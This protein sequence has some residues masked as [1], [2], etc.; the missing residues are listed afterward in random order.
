MDEE[1]YSALTEIDMMDFGSVENHKEKV[2]WF[3]PTKT[4]MKDSG[5]RENETDMEF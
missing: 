3:T 1:L 2:E 4:S 5:M